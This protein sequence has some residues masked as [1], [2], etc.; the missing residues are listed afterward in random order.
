MRKNVITYTECKTFGHSWGKAPASTPTNVTYG[1]VL[2]CSRC[3]ALRH[4]SFD[5]YFD[6]KRHYEYPKDYSQGIKLS[7]QELREAYMNSANRIHPR[8]TLRVVS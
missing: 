8:R 7:K 3:A 4:D 1:V 6:V 2:R 5:D